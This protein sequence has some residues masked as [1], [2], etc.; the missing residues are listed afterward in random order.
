MLRVSAVA[1]ISDDCSPLSSRWRSSS[2]FSCLLVVHPFAF[3]IRFL[4]VALALKVYVLGFCLFLDVYNVASV[5]HARSIITF[6]ADTT[7]LATQQLRRFQLN[8]LRIRLTNNTYHY[9]FHPLL[10]S[11][12]PFLG[13]RR[14][15]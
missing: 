13:L 5:S 11:D 6:S 8:K 2:A 3:V 12:C 4:F 7:S 14:Q 1:L 15:S 9:A 10:Q